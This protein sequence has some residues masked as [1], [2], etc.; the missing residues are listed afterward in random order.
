M[1]PVTV[2]GLSLQFDIADNQMMDKQALRYV[3]Q[4]ATDA[5]KKALPQ[6]QPSLF[7]HTSSDK[8]DAGP[9]PFLY[10]RDVTVGDP[11]E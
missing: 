11:Y 5:M 4:Q 1:R 3:L 9:R 7:F 2:E 6:L 10:E 8:G